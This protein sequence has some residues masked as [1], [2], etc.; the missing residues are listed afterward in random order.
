MAVLTVDNAKRKPAGDFCQ[1]VRAGAC[2]AD[3][4]VD[5]TAG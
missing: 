2:V 4:V 3:P 5:T 1:H